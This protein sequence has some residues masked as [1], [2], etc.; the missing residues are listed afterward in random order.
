MAGVLNGSEEQRF[1]DRIRCITYREIRDEVIARTRNSFITRKWISEKLH[2][3]ETWVQRKSNTGE[4][5]TA[6]KL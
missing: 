6:C 2:R 5:K 3:D 1:L 4:N